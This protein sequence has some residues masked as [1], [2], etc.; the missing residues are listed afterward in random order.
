MP[1]D[2]KNTQTL[3]HKLAQAAL[4]HDPASGLGVFLDELCYRFGLDCLL[5][6]DDGD[7][8]PG[9]VIRARHGDSGKAEGE[10]LLLPSNHLFAPPA[11]GANE[12]LVV[13]DAKLLAN[14]LGGALA[15]ADSAKYRGA[16]ALRQG[17]ALGSAGI[18]CLLRPEQLSQTGALSQTLDGLKP[19]MAE[20]FSTF[21]L[22]DGLLARSLPWRETVLAGRVLVPGRAAGRV[23]YLNRFVDLD[24]HR[25]ESSDDPGAE[26]EHLDKALTQLETIFSQA[27]RHKESPIEDVG[28][29]YE[30]FLHVLADASFRDELKRLIDKGYTA[31]SAVV[32]LARRYQDSFNRIGDEYLR[33]RRHDFIY[34]AHRLVSALEGGGRSREREI[35][36]G[37]IILAGDEIGVPDI[38]MI[39]SG[40][41]AAIIAHRGSA[42]AHASI[43]ARAKSVPLVSG[44]SPF[45]LLH[46]NNRDL[47]VDGEA[48]QVIVEPG[49]S[50]RNKILSAASAQTAQRPCA[51]PVG[52]VCSSD[53]VPVSCY[54]NLGL[55]E[56]TAAI[57]RRQVC[58]IGLFRSEI[59]FHSQIN[60][61]SMGNQTR[62]Y[63]RLLSAFHPA[64]VWMRLLDIGRDKSLQ[65][66]TT[67]HAK[68]D[69]CGARMLIDNPEILGKQLEAM[70]R[71]NAMLGNLRILVPN[72]TQMEEIIIIRR[73]V[74]ELHQRLGEELHG[75]ERPMLGAMIEVPGLIFLIDHLAH[76]VEYISIGSN[77]LLRNLLLADREDQASVDYHSFLSPAL[78][79]ALS[80]IVKS[81]SKAGLRLGICGEALTGRDELMMCLG[82]G[83]RQISVASASVRRVR[84]RIA[85]LRVSQCQ[86]LHRRAC[87]CETAEEVR[88]L[89]RPPGDAHAFKL[90]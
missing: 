80:T 85:G 52:V 39:P 77:D 19:A 42:L 1:T 9:L 14:L 59:Y 89:L 61:P 21:G 55:F 40:R 32:L 76:Y 48:G 10:R 72:V 37:H 25:I 4:A 33:E 84:L 74:D 8:S 82:A 66:F 73:L 24:Q 38:M 18:L 90:A 7:G 5:W 15:V 64:P 11:G 13:N 50:Q 31:K 69:W 17:T 47:I 34:L 67:D 16:L 87:E 23:V 71:A 63:R 6:V 56:E 51:G 41:L 26:R 20:V 83:L 88:Q 28:Y 43:L 58:G 86:S 35:N 27:V 46:M 81:A 45:H 75:L 30:L 3:A 78:Q 79:R 60:F 57:D 49:Q 44:I 65:Y 12:V 29:I 54:A 62:Y 70:M 68:R 22:A 53:G 36:K 2:K